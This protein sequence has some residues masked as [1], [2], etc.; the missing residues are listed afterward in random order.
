MGTCQKVG[1]GAQHP[2]AADWLP[3]LLNPAPS[4]LVYRPQMSSWSPYKAVECYFLEIAG[5]PTTLALHIVAHSPSPLSLHN[6]DS[7]I[8]WTTSHFPSHRPPPSLEVPSNRSSIT[9]NLLHQTAILFPNPNLPLSQSTPA[10]PPHQPPQSA[11]PCSHIEPLTAPPIPRPPLQS[12]L[13]QILFFANGG[14][15]FRPAQAH[16]S[17]SPFPRAPRP[18][19]AVPWVLLHL[20]R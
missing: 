19:P 2:V 18:T 1:L 4:L 17:S 10:L 12:N 20:R 7:P 11:P 15:Y 8:R 16:P 9:S 6:P 5:R 13:F 14:P 3:V